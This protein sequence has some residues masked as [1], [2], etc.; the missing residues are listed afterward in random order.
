MPA[1]GGHAVC[2]SFYQAV[3][4]AL[5][6]GDVRRLRLLWEVS[7]QVTV[8][9]R[10]KPTAH[11]LV[12]DRLNMN[13][14]LRIKALGSGVQSFFQFCCDV[15]T[16]P[17]VDEPQL[18]SVKLVSFLEEFGVTYKGKAIDKSMGFA[19]LA[20]MPFA[21]DKGCRESVEIL[22]RIEPKA[23]DDHTKVMRCCQRVKNSSASSEHLDNFVFATESMAVSLLGGNTK[24][25]NVF[26]V[27][28]LVGKAK[29]EPGFMKTHVTKKRLV[30]WF[31]DQMSAEISP[32]ASGAAETIITTEGYQK[33]RRRFQ[34]PHKFF[35]TFARA[36]TAAEQ[37][38]CSLRT[39]VSDNLATFEKS[40]AGTAEAAAMEF[41][42]IILVFEG[43][44]EARDLAVSA[45]SFA[46]YFDNAGA[47]DECE[48]EYEGESPLLN[49][50]RS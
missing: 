30:A 14:Q 6:A 4:D 28:N 45:R 10:L 42:T 20:V 13:D 8:R 11:Q 47:E 46:S 12:L 5:V 16:L 25:P 49:A 31:L 19:L 40:L 9:L 35:Q 48:D 32:A 44:G 41:L 1:S 17:K 26:T 29:G 24:D 43:D 50:Y 36:R 21:L 38:Q 33:L 18:S 2:W 37:E 3:D 34:S 27:E 23:F 7:N 39:L 15:F 22:E